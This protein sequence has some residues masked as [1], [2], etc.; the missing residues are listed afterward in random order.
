MQKFAA[1]PQTGQLDRRTLAKM[2]APRC[3]LPD[4]IKPEKKMMGNRTQRA[5]RF[6]LYGPK[7]QRMPITWW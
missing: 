2:T 6:V 7:W 5:K 1:L 3:G 4:V